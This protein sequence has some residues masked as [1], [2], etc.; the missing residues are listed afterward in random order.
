VKFAM[1]RGV[2]GYEHYIGNK[3]NEY[4]LVGPDGALRVLEQ[5][6]PKDELSKRDTMRLAQRTKELQEASSTGKEPTPEEIMVD[7]V[8]RDIAMR[9]VRGFRREEGRSLPPAFVDSLSTLLP[10]DQER[11]ALLDEVYQRLIVI[12]PRKG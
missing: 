8:G 7:P 2:V 5:T 6:E 9:L 12:T 11:L 3:K 10:L 4:R 1:A